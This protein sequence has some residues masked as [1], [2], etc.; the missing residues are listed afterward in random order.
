MGSSFG[1]GARSGVNLRGDFNTGNVTVFEEG[2]ED[3]APKEEEKKQEEVKSGEGGD[4]EMAD[5]EAK[6]EAVKAEEGGKTAEGKKGPVIVVEEEEEEEGVVKDEMEE[7]ETKDEPTST[8]SSL[9]K[10]PSAAVSST[11]KPLTPIATP[12][13]TPSPSI[14]PLT[15][16]LTSNES[17][18]TTFWSLQTY[19]ADPTTLAS[20]TASTSGSSTPRPTFDEF[21]FKADRV[22]DA[23][24]KETEKERV[25]RGSGEGG[26]DGSG[27]GKGREVALSGLD[28]VFMPK[29]LTSPGLLGFEVSLMSFVLE[30]EKTSLIS[31]AFRFFSLHSSQTF[32]FVVRSSSNSSSS[33]TSSDPSPQAHRRPARSSSKR[34]LASRLMVRM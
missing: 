21:R 29:F 23:L 12:S 26:K 25:L 3:E 7:G 32:P 27:K 4:V 15:P 2:V 8:H 28:E 6:D 10:K 11:I 24:A 13:A 30:Y 33:T 16:A 18:Y 9:P 1:L 17:F 22:I 31:V 34:C 20:L 19:F 14:P 5:G